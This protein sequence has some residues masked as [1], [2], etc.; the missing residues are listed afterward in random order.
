LEVRLRLSRR[1]PEVVVEASF[2]NS[3]AANGG[4]REIWA[5]SPFTLDRDDLVRAHAEDPSYQTYGGRLSDA[6]FSGRVRELF[7]QSW[8]AVAQ[9]RAAHPERP[10]HGLRIRLR[11]DPSWNGFGWETVVNP[12]DSASFLACDQNIT[13]TREVTAKNWGGLVAAEFRRALLI[14]ASPTDLKTYNLPPINVADHLKT[15]TESLEAAGLT[16][17]TLVKSSETTLP[18]VVEEMGAAY[19]VWYVVCHGSV[20][21]SRARI[22]LTQ[23]DGAVSQVDVA[24]IEKAVDSI[25]KKPSLVFLLSCHGGGAGQTLTTAGNNLAWALGPRM[26]RSGVPAVIA[27]QGAIGQA[28]AQDFATK[29]LESLRNG[30]DVEAAVAKARGYIHAK[31]YQDWWSPCLFSLAGSAPVIVDPE[32]VFNGWDVLTT[33]IRIGQCIPILGFGVGEPLFGPVRRL[34]QRVARKW[35]HPFWDSSPVDLP[36][37]AQYARV[38]K[39]EGEYPKQTLL[40][41]ICQEIFSNHLGDF[42]AATRAQLTK[43]AFIDRPIGELRTIIRSLAAQLRK[44]EDDPYRI[45]A[46]LPCRYY[47]TTMPDELLEDAIKERTQDVLGTEY[48]REPFTQSCQWREVRRTLRQEQNEKQQLGDLVDR[49]NMRRREQISR[50]APDLELIISSDLPYIYHLFGRLDPIDDWV[51]TEDEYFQF[52]NAASGAQ[53]MIPDHL[54]TAIIRST[55]LFVGFEL[56]QWSFRVLLQIIQQALALGKKAHFAVQLNTTDA[57]GGAQLAVM[58]Y[59]AERFR[60]FAQITIYWG[61]TQQ[62]LMEL[63]TEL[64]KP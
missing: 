32:R 59:L 3:R 38:T 33:K 21:Q 15:A 28:C 54:H 7:A 13:V 17:H 9:E 24:E 63:R 37:V 19:D 20:N 53:N 36:T 22:F 46:S 18:R 11:Y 16:V 44:R 27:M 4:A 23:D 64:M 29:T 62:F 43:G 25:Q 12:F 47:I 45:L 51:V 49:Y 40:A 42:D 6:L 1:D 10:D 31:K 50:E 52:L 8:G 48:P 58:D 60:D 34:V 41:E 57:E 35:G 56:N 14:I 30:G 2:T 5:E 55:L 26:V 61:S 39:K